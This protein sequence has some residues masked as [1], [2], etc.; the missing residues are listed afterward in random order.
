MIL[1]TGGLLGIGGEKVAVPWDKIR[2]TPNI[3][4]LTADVTQSEIQQYSHGKKESGGGSQETAQS[5]RRESPMPLAQ[6]DSNRAKE[7]K[8]QKMAGKNGEELGRVTELFTG[9]DGKPMYVI[10][11]DESK[12]MHPVPAQLVHTNPKDKSLSADL[13]KQAFQSSPGFD[14][15]QISEQ[16]QW[17][18]RVRSYYQS[19]FQ[20]G[21]P[22][23]QQPQ[24]PMSGQPSQQQQSRGPG[25]SQQQQPTPGAGQFQ[26]Q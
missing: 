21:Q 23:G 8:N 7:F 19:D 13:D 6:V 9:Q 5:D 22:G 24:P 20:G 14:Q 16:R 25:Q 12:K 3:D 2:S 26:N 15:A 17:E 10:V 18:P 4:Q 1:S 11:Q